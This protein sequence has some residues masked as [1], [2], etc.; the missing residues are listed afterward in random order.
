MHVGCTTCPTTSGRPSANRWGRREAVLIHGHNPSDP[1]FGGRTFDSDPGTEIVT[2]DP[3]PWYAPWETDVRFSAD[4][5]S[6]YW[7]P[8]SDHCGT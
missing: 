5:H 4:A 1:G 8:N 3:G 7:Y 6:Q 2:V